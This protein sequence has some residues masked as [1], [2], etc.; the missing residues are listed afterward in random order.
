MNNIHKIILPLLCLTFYCCNST[1]KTQAEIDKSEAMIEK[2][3]I[4]VHSEEA[5]TRN[6]KIENETSIVK[7]LTI[8]INALNKPDISNSKDSI[9]SICDNQLNRILKLKKEIE[10]RHGITKNGELMIPRESKFINE[11]FLKEGK[12]K[13]LKNS[14]KLTISKLITISNI[15]E[16][17]ITA[18]SLPLQLNLFMEKQNKTWENYTFENMPAGAVEPILESFKNNI[19]LTKILLLERLA[20]K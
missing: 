18:D 2:S 20:A 1:K 4:Y 10:S 13:E 17:A 6:Y 11:I 19:I 8:K 16:L 7:S 5:K 9:I 3:L 12:G 15:N 14:I